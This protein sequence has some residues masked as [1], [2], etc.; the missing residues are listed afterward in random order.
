MEHQSPGACI[1]KQYE[2]VINGKTEV[3]RNV[4]YCNCG[5]VNY[6]F[7]FYNL[8]TWVCII[9]LITAVINSVAWYANMLVQGSKKLNSN[10]KDTNLHNLLQP[11]KVL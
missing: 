10:N 5:L 7:V 1:E 11:L 4:F 8:D 9:K 2:S 6:E 3:L